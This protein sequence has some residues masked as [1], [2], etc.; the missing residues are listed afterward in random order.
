MSRL[1][2]FVALLLFASCGKFSG[3]TYPRSVTRPVTLHYIRSCYSSYFDDFAQ[4]PDK[5]KSAMDDYLRKRM[6][7]VYFG[8]LSFEMGYVLSDK[9]TEIE[10]SE[11]DKGV[12]ALLGLD[13][14]EEDCDSSIAFPVYAAIFNLEIPEVGID[15]IALNIMIDSDG[16]PVREVEFPQI[17]SG[18]QLIPIDSVHAK[19][20]RRRIPA[21]NLEIRL[22]YD[23]EDGSLIW[24]TRT[25]VG[26]G[27]IAGTSCIAEYQ[28]H[29]DMNA[30]TGEVVETRSGRGMRN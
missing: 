22:L 14:V 13:E 4:V 19:L 5:A 28:Y 10:V 9:P 11:N 15:K 7:S 3:E 12:L 29:F 21:S 6:G 24:S 18:S 20:I 25:L 16:M 8:K 1:T 23:E 30:I 17:P 26:E 27:T 2:F